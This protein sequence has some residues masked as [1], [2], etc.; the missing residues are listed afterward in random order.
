MPPI[1]PNRPRPTPPV[2]SVPLRPADLPPVRFDDW[3]AI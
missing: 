2:A 1:Q 3:A